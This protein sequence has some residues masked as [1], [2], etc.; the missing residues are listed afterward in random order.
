[1]CSFPRATT[2]TTTCSRSVPPRSQPA[3]RPSSAAREREDSMRRCERSA[4]G[5]ER[6][7]PPGTKGSTQ[8]GRFRT[9]LT[10]RRITPEESRIYQDGTIVGEVYRQED[11]L[12]RGPALLRDPPLG[13][14]SRPRQGARARSHSRRSPAPRGH[15]SA[16]V[17]TMAGAV[18]FPRLRRATS[19]KGRVGRPLASRAIRCNPPSLALA[20]IYAPIPVASARWRSLRAPLSKEKEA[21][22]H[23]CS[24]RRVVALCHTCSLQQPCGSS[25][26]LR[27]SPRGRPFAP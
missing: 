9:D 26:A 19:F 3:S 6:T 23:E 18:F 22:I 27:P 15:A 2:S 17:V 11:I 5:T 25:A 10:F 24:P 21:G 20:G 16:V 14:P 4:G 12:N 8:M 7:R 1:M 13:G